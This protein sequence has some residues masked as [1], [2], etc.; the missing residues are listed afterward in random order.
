MAAPGTNPVPR[1]H[2]KLQLVLREA[3]APKARACKPT[4]D[5]ESHPEWPSG[6]PPPPG[7][8]CRTVH[9]WVAALGGELGTTPSRLSEGGGHGTAQDPKGTCPQ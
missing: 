2:R 3:A 4:S 7:N 8:R 5:S 1:K 9:P 6:H